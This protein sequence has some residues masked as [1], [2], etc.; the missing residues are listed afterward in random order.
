MSDQVVFT[1]E[2]VE[3]IK[4][5]LRDNEDSLCIDCHGCDG[6]AKV[7]CR[8]KK[9]IQKALSILDSPRPTINIPYSVLSEVLDAW[10]A[11]DSCINVL[12]KF[13]FNIED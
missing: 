11:G 7:I 3:K 8:E 9:A 5:T 12:S 6:C 4:A 1:K 13:G 2:E 10:E